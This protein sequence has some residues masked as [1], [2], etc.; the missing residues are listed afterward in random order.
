VTRCEQIIA[1][2]VAALLEAN[3]YSAAAGRDGTK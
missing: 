1:G 2:K 3:K